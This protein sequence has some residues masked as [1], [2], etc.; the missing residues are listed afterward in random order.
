MIVCHTG[1]VEEAEEALRPLRE[2]G[3]PAL[4]MVGPMPYVALQKLVD[5]SYPAGMRNYWTGDFLAGL[6]DEAIEVLARFHL[7]T[8]SPMTQIL[9]LPGGGALAQVPDGTMA[10][11]ERQAPFN[12]H[13]TSLWP[14][15]ADDD[16]NIAWTRD[17]SNALKSYTRR[18]YVN[19]IGDEGEDRVVAVIWP[20]MSACGSQAALRPQNRSPATRTSSRRL[21]Q[22]RRDHGRDSGAGWSVGIGS[23]EQVP[24]CTSVASHRRRG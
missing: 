12:I 24:A 7:S 21:E 14:D 5:D 1:P 15:P 20:R 23:I 9:V 6:P 3:P 17:L 8:P 16:A 4:D 18:V 2:F 11:G 19:F 22:Q 13:I 10:I